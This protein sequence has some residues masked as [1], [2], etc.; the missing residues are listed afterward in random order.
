MRQQRTRLLFFTVG[1][2]FVFTPAVL[3]AQDRIDNP[4]LVG[5][6]VDAETGAPLLGAWVGPVNQDWGTY[7]KDD[8]SFLLPR[9]YSGAAYYEVS[10]LG[11]ESLLVELTP[12]ETFQIALSPDPIAL[13][14]IR[15]VA[16]RFKRRRNAFPYSVR[17]IERDQLLANAS[18]D[19]VDFVRGRAGVRVVPCPRALSYQFECVMRRGRAQAM[20]VCLD[21]M[22]YYG[23]VNGLR[24]MHPHEFALVEVFARGAHVRLYTPDFMARAGRRL[25][26]VPPLEFGM[27]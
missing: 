24:D 1:L 5:K 14:G 8:G 22:P 6:V 12:G 23:G 13:E 18:T 16:D 7:S 4:P 3:M 17:A 19:M 26:N 27:C 15:V 2:V 11:Y 9:V 21:E 20:T 10:M 25:M